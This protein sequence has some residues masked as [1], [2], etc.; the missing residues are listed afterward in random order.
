MNELALNN[1]SSNQTYLSIN[2]NALEQKEKAKLLN[3]IMNPQH[4]VSDMIN[5]TISVVD[6]YAELVDM[7][8]KDANGVDIPGEV[9]AT[10]RIILIDDKGE[11]YQCVSW[12]VYSAIQKII[13]FFGEP[14][15]WDGPQKIKVTQTQKG[16]KQI[17]G[18]SLA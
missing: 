17:L 13:Q 1:A 14:C 6:I 5:M 2:V 15:T 10:P 7:P 16:A 4:R 9:V 18:L 12:G 11:G 8:A 3:A